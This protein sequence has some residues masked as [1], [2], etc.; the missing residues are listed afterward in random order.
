MRSGGHGLERRLAQQ[1]PLQESSLEVGGLLAP[2]LPRKPSSAPALGLDPTGRSPP[3]AHGAG[4]HPSCGDTESCFLRTP[5]EVFCTIF[6][7]QGLF[8]PPLVHGTQTLKLIFNTLFVSMPNLLKIPW[9]RE[10]DVECLLGAAGCGHTV[11]MH[12][13]AHHH[14]RHGPSPRPAQSR[15]CV[16]PGCP[17]A[18]WGGGGATPSRAEG[19]AFLISPIPHPPV[20]PMSATPRPRLVEKLRLWWPGGLTKVPAA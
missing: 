7:L 13:T 20:K 19:L 11:T 15:L 1:H 5:L 3:G 16:R 9:Q 12:G 14:A 2:S 6:R 4:V 18:G 10:Q 8:S 17:C